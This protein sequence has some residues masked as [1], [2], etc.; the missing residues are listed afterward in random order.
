MLTNEKIIDEDQEAPL[1]FHDFELL[2]VS[3]EEPMRSLPEIKEQFSG[4]TYHGQ[5]EGNQSNQQLSVPFDSSMQYPKTSFQ[6]LPD[7]V[8]SLPPKN[9]KKKKLKKGKKRRNKSNLPPRQ[10]S[11]I[12]N[13][14]PIRIGSESVGT[15]KFGGQF[16]VNPM[17]FLSIKQHPD[18]AS[19]RERPAPDKLAAI[20]KQPI[21]RGRADS[22]LKTQSILSSLN[23]NNQSI[24]T[25]DN[26]MAMSQL[27][28]MKAL[29]AKALNV[30][31]DR[32]HA[33]NF[34]N[35]KHNFLN[36]Y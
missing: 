24:S 11:I 6:V 4:P 7:Y 28:H 31:E 13:K 15:Q 20:Y 26:S 18:Q 25:M 2:P 9:L 5:I 3:K 30:A 17:N 10:G 36:N 19:A 34:S 29:Q 27:H 22:K 14:S 32:V 8:S 12:D 35:Q 33:L 16:S 21:L 23:P 1:L